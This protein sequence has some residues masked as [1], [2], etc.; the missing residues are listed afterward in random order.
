MRRS[1]L[2]R[3]A[4]VPSR[5]RRPHRRRGNGGCTRDPP[6]RA[7]GT[8]QAASGYAGFG[9]TSAV[10]PLAVTA[11]GCDSGGRAGR[12]IDLRQDPA[13]GTVGQRGGCRPDEA[14]HLT[15]DEFV[16]GHK[17][18]TA[19]TVGNAALLWLARLVRFVRTDATRRAGLVCWM[20]PGVFEVHQHDRQE[21]H[22]QQARRPAVSLQDSS[23]SRL[24]RLGR[25][26]SRRWPRAHSGPSSLPGEPAEP[27]ERRDPARPAR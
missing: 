23:T 3:F 5:C 24:R 19:G 13:S 18:G 17:P 1:P 6:H 26:Y 16:G 27:G 2:T 10:N 7:T 9:R 14:C 11:R 25:P 15:H 22:R 20:T 8:V 4:G 12:T 21:D